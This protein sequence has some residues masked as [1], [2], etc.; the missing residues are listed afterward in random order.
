MLKGALQMRWLVIL[1]PLI[2]NTACDRFKLEEVQEKEVQVYHPSNSLIKPF[3][4]DRVKY[5][6]STTHK[7]CERCK[8]NTPTKKRLSK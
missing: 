7:T 1:L 4:H 6:V 8:K 2:L 3:S 5:D